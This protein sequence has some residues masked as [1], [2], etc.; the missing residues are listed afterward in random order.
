MVEKLVPDPFIKSQNRVYPWINIQKHY[1]D[2]LLYFQ[3]EF[4]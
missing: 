1:K 3:V 4:Y 2:F